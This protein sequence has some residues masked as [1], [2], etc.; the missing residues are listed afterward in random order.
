[1]APSDEPRDR[2]GPVL[3]ASDA[4]RAVVAA[5]RNL[6]A[7]VD[8]LDRGSYL[9]VRVP[10]TCIVTRGAIEE[11]LGDAFV[12]PSDLERLMLSSA[13]TLHLTADQAVW[14]SRAGQ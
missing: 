11:A 12:L 14:T 2:V 3:E 4:G 1:M 10:R 8:V 13:G 5:I 7:D 9:R 6:N